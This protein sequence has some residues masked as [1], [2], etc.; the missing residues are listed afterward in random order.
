M[1][2]ELGGTVAGIRYRMNAFFTGR[3]D[4]G[5]TSDDVT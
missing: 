5:S 1:V 2:R 3:D 4:G